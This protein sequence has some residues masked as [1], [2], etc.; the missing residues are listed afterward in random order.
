LNKR[1]MWIV[2]I[3]VTPRMAATAILDC[4]RSCRQSWFWVVIF[5]L[6][7]KLNTYYSDQVTAIKLN[8]SGTVG[9]RTTSTVCRH[10]C[11]RH[12][13]FSRKEHLKEKLF[14]ERYY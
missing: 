10:N 8:N 11:Y 5:S 1:V 6:S 9:L 4:F 7:V 12:H 14:L 2:A 3:K 13:G